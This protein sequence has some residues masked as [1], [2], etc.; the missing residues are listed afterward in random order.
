MLDVWTPPLCNQHKL[1]LTVTSAHGKISYQLVTSRKT[2]LDK[3]VPTVFDLG[4]MWLDKNNGHRKKLRVT[5]ALTERFD[6]YKTTRPYKIHIKKNVV[7]VKRIFDMEMMII[8][9]IF[10]L[11]S[12]EIGQGK[13][14][15][16]IPEC[17]SRKV[18]QCCKIIILKIVW[19]DKSRVKRFLGPN[20]WSEDHSFLWRS[21]FIFLNGLLIILTPFIKANDNSHNWSEMSL[22]HLLKSHTWV[23]VWNLLFLQCAC[24]ICTGVNYCR[25]KVTLITIK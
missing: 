14:K 25:F 11:W 3:S 15:S 20:Q 6:K 16:L 18:H 12:R 23:Y 2:N 8:R 24:L 1:K 4:K 7:S 9:W 19:I 13:I 21:Y 22:F 10:S 17:F 5:E